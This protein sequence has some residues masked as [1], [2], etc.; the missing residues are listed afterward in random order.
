MIEV[1]TSLGTLHLDH[2][3]W[4]SGPDFALP[5]LLPLIQATS[6]RV[7]FVHQGAEDLATQVMQALGQQIEAIRMLKPEDPGTDVFFDDD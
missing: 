1:H 3:V 7:A 2:G 6:D 4:T 5:E